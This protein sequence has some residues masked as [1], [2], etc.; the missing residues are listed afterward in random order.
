MNPSRKPDTEVLGFR[1]EVQTGDRILGVFRIG[2]I[3]GLNEI[4]RE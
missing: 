3:S 4:I 2:K 1:G